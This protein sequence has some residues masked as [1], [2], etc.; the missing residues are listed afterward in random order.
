MSVVELPVLTASRPARRADRGL[1]YTLYFTTERTKRTES[2]LRPLCGDR[3]PRRGGVRSPLDSARSV[4]ASA[5][6]GASRLIDVINHTR[7]GGATTDT[8]ASAASLPANPPTPP[9][10][11]TV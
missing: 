9:V 11:R 3:A 2:S 1:R 10:V 6:D 5:R 7:H 8:A 4:P